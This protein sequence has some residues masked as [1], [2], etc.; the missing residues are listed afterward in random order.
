MPP[1]NSISQHIKRPKIPQKPVPQS[2]VGGRMQRK[3]LFLSAILFTTAALSLLWLTTTGS[4][5]YLHLKKLSRE[6]EASKALNQKLKND[7]EELQLSIEKLK[8]DPVEIEKH[9]REGL[10][11]YRRGEIIYT[12]EHAKD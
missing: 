7:V 3:F 4:W 6:V 12:F 1:P 5:G 2:Y 9:A 10:G 11:M 8:S